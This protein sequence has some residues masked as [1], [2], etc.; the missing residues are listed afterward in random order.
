MMVRATVEFPLPAPTCDGLKVQVDKFGR[1][2]QENATAL[3]KLPVFGETPTV[4]SAVCPTGT[5]A[6]VGVALIAK[7]KF[8]AGSTI[9]LTAAECA[10]FA[11]SLPTAL[12]LNE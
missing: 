5:E 9:K 12:I 8:C 3:E 6:E 1:F 4:N 2:V 11:E 7:S 10:T